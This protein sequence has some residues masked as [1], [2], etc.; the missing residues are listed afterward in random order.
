MGHVSRSHLIRQ[1]TVDF[2][3][4]HSVMSM[5]VALGSQLLIR[6]TLNNPFIAWQLPVFNIVVCF[7]PHLIVGCSTLSKSHSKWCSSAIGVLALRLRS[8]L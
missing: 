3:F 6:D 4:K 7:S 1:K 5:K 2:M 8:A